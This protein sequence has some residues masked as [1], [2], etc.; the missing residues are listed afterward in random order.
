MINEERGL[1]EMTQADELRQLREHI[2]SDVSA[3]HQKFD[4]TID[5]L[6]TKL[7]K[8]ND[9]NNEQHAALAQKLAEVDKKTEV[10]HAVLVTKLGLLV[11]GISLFV[12][13]MASWAFEH[14]MGK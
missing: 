2:R 11:T 1:D 14:V 13:A 3:L 8:F 6:H 4:Q 5:K 9:E 10:K 12:T 7:D